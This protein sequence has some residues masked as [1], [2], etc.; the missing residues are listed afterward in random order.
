MTGHAEKATALLQVAQT[1]LGSGSR[2]E[3]VSAASV[4]AQLA[5]VE[6]TTGLATAVRDLTAAL[7]DEEKTVDQISTDAV[8]RDVAAIG[9]RP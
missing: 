5:Q 1:Q 2:F 3:A 9:D 7:V 8:A 4:H 6:A